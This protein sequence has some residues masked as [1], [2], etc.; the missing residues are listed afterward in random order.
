MT[1][2]LMLSCGVFMLAT[3]SS[4]NAQ[5]TADGWSVVGEIGSASDLIGVW[6]VMAGFDLDND[7]NREFFFT[8]DPSSSGGAGD[9]GTDTVPWKAYYYEADGDNTYVERWGWA[10]PIARN[11]GLRGFPAMQVGDVDQDGLPEFWF[12]VPNEVENDPPNPKR[13]YV[14]EH[15][16]VSL[17]TSP[18]ESWDLGMAD[19][20]RF[21]ISGIA[22]EDLDADGDI[23]MVLQSRNDDFTGAGAGRTMLIANSGGVDIGIGFGAFATEFMETE[24]L[25]GGGVYDPR[26]VDFDRDG[27]PEVWIF[28]WDFFTLA[29]YEATAPN[30]YTLQTEIDEVFPGIDYGTRMAA[31]FYDADG[32]GELEMYTATLSGDGD[33]GS[34]IIY[35]GSTDDVSTLT[36]ADVQILGGRNADPGHH[37]GAVGDI[38]GDGLMDYLYISSNDATGK[39]S[40]VTRMEYS[41][42]GDLADSTSYDWSIFFEN[43][44]AES[45]LRGIAIDDIDG[46]EKTEVLLTNLDV[47]SSAETI[48][49]ILERDNPVSVEETPQVVRGFALAQNYPNPFNPST[50]IEFNLETTEQVRITVYNM[51]GQKLSTIV[52]ERLSAGSYKASFEAGDLQSGIFFYTIE[53]GTFRETRKMVLLK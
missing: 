30:T 53:A 38:D 32:N 1:S 17:P 43:T 8:T 31:R 37:G 23:E 52:N 11:D 20:F 19:N 13:L 21:I 44:N 28:T 25:K 2:R 4:V 35:M 15:D 42:S 29:I 14:F 24:R 26:I 41:G 33:P 36:A 27:V 18:S 10:P 7:G 9:V 49:Y 40:Q 6:E 34:V 46:D 51:L 45:D 39:R 48:L 3:F 16:G 47:A 50:T 5:T 22:F 12:G